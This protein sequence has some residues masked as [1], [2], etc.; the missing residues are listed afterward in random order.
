MEPSHLELDELKNECK[1]RKIPYKSEGQA[2]RDLR[3]QVRKE[4]KSGQPEIKWNEIDPYQ[5]LPICARLMI[6]LY[7]TTDLDSYMRSRVS[8]K[9][10]FSRL[11]HLKARTK[12]I[13][14]AVWI[15]HT[16]FIANIDTVVKSTQWLI[17]EYFSD[18]NESDV[19]LLFED[20]EVKG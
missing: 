12:R 5:E 14:F 3:I 19:G 2:L 1:I 18:F 7:E 11:C 16:E 9:M 15:H 8:K 13:Y 10:L 4:M 20:D 17:D 6:E